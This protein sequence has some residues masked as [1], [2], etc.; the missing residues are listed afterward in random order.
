V[1]GFE[2]VGKDAIAAWRNLLGPT[3][4]LTA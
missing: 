2:L 1:I 4:T 3:N